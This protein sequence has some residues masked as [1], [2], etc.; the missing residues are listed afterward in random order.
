[1][2]LRTSLILA[3]LLVFVVASPAHAYLDPGTGSQIFQILLAVFVGGLFSLK[4]F[5]GRIKEYFSSLGSG[6]DE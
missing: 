3:M 2:K 4:V 5:W 1:M 6:S